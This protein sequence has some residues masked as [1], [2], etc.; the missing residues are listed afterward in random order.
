MTDNNKNN[1]TRLR[2]TLKNSP[3]NLP[4]ANKNTAHKNSVQVTIKGRK[5]ESQEIVNNSSKEI[6]ARFL[7]IAKSQQ[8]EKR[9]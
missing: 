7:A 5:K 4:I 1:N 2:L 6:E 9:N 8:N 3:T